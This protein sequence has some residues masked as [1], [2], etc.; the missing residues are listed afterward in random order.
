MEY[1]MTLRKDE[2]MK[3]ASIWMYLGE[4]NAEQNESMERDRH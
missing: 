1:Y 2:V 3:F 4:N